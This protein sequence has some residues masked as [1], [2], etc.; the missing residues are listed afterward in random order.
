MQDAAPKLYNQTTDEPPGENMGPYTPQKIIVMGLPKTGTT[1][2]AQAFRA[3]GYNV[4]HNMGDTL[5]RCKVIANTMEY[6]YK[7]LDR[8]HPEATWVITYAKNATQWV[9]SWITHLSQQNHKFGV[10]AQTHE[11]LHMN[12]SL[13]LMGFPDGEYPVRTQRATR[14][15]ME[16]HA[17]DYEAH[18]QKYYREL[19]DYFGDRMQYMPI[20]DVRAG[21][22]YDKLF[23]IA[24]NHSDVI[25]P[26]VPFPH[27]NSR[28]KR[29][30]WPKC[31]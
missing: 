22:G 11:K 14:T 24:R 21:D 28:D 30:G 3:L 18:Y 20:V 19:F 23:S 15:F 31:H 9:D 8:K 27:A 13:F 29:G 1:S 17:Q 16:K 26:G 10:I 12:R 2:L 4:S 25:T 6:Q 7:Q 5:G